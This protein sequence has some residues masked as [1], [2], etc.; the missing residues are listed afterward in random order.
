MESLLLALQQREENAKPLV[1]FKAGRMNKSGNLIVPDKKRGKIV[2]NMV[3][4]FFDRKLE[5]VG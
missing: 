5:A 2:L 4:Y 1:E 3:C